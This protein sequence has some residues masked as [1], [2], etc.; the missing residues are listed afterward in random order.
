MKGIS[1]PLP[2]NWSIFRQETDYDRVCVQTKVSSTHR[3]PSGCHLSCHSPFSFSC[4]GRGHRSSSI[5]TASGMHLNP[6]LPV[7]VLATPRAPTQLQSQRN[8]ESQWRV[9]P[10]QRYIAQSDASRDVLISSG[11]SSTLDDGDDE[12]LEYYAGGLIS[13]PAYTVVQDIPITQPSY[14]LTAPPVDDDYAMLAPATGGRRPRSISS[15]MRR[16]VLM[17][18]FLHGRSRTPQ[19]CDWCRNRKTKCSGARPSCERC[20]SRGLPCVYA[21]DQSISRVRVRSLRGAESRMDTMPVRR[22]VLLSEDQLQHPAY[23]FMDV[24]WNETDYAAVAAISRLPY[25]VAMPNASVDL[26]HPQTAVHSTYP[27]HAVLPSQ[28]EFSLPPSGSLGRYRENTEFEFGESGE[29]YYS[30]PS[31]SQSTSSGSGSSSLELTMLELSDDSA[32]GSVGSSDSFGF[33]PSDSF[34][35]YDSSS[36]LVSAC[37]QLDPSTASSTWSLVSA[38][39][40]AGVDTSF[41][42]RPDMQGMLDSLDNDITSQAAAGTAQDL[43]L[44]TL[45]PS[46]RS[47][48]DAS[49]SN[50]TS[51][52]P[53]D[54]SQEFF[55][56]SLDSEGDLGLLAPA[57]SD[58][59][60]VAPLPID[61]N[62]TAQTGVDTSA[63]SRSSPDIALP[64]VKTRGSL[65]SEDSSQNSE[66]LVAA[67]ATSP[68]G[69]DFD[70]SMADIFGSA[71]SAEGAERGKS[72]CDWSDSS[73][74]DLVSTRS[75]DANASIEAETSAQSTALSGPEESQQPSDDTPCAASKA[76]VQADAD[77][78][79]TRTSG[80]LYTELFGD[81]NGD[82][83]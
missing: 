6:F 69:A 44:A 37:S 23:E 59:F 72:G 65:P 48:S 8:A 9:A 79:T 5:F 28:F 71:M 40:F 18:D 62:S 24:P 58:N 25:A 74:K 81:T 38:P 76:S 20:V 30:R 64:S 63:T 21:M 2:E 67:V 66:D 80:M 17:H 42:S 31:S 36:S 54:T 73:S 47:N 57:V 35:S 82:R 61:T 78:S 3:Q 1:Q 34:L 16:Q 45:S 55:D 83:M 46:S 43:G 32:R 56:I 49:W 10:F 75:P 68:L 15:A 60:I 11:L 4:F 41:L 50:C 52:L 77:G 53:T 33:L 12:E 7:D 19:A 13:S 14:V 22:R 29:S 26:M 51:F 39:S 70:K 27:L